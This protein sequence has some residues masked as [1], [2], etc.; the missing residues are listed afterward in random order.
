VRAIDPTH[1]GYRLTTSRGVFETGIV[2]DAGGPRGAK[3]VAGL[4]D[5]TIPV[6]AT[7]HQVVSYAMVTG[8]EAPF[9]M[10]F[11]VAEGWY[12]RPEEQGAIVGISNPAE[13]PD[14]SGRYQL[15]FDWAFHE[16][17]RPVW[18]DA[19]PPVAGQPISRVW[20]ASIDYTPDHLPIIDQ[21]KPGFFVVA[22][23]GHGMMCGPGLGLKTAELI[24]TGAI[25]ELPAEEIRLNRFAAGRTAPSKDQIALPF[26][27]EA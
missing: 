5:V 21:P 3:H 15:G 24:A 6:S 1:A 12:V 22:A 4:L 10:A 14:P 7:R 27:A 25:S 23:G 13:Q 26:P 19:F 20:A 11:V 17:Q 16:A 9:P 8:I 2:V 18:E